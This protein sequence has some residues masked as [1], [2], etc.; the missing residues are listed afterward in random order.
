MKPK[1]NIKSS[2][3]STTETTNP[4]IV[5]A[6][7]LNMQTI[8]YAHL[9]ITI[10]IIYIIV[11]LIVRIGWDH[12]GIELFKNYYQTDKYRNLIMDFLL[13]YVYLK[14]AELLPIN[15]PIVY[16][17]LLIIIF[18]NVGFSFYLNKTSYQTGMIGFLKEWSSTVGWF[19]ILW[20]IFYISSLGKVSDQINKIKLIKKDSIQLSIILLIT[21]ILLHL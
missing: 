21:F 10:I 5:N 14:A 6:Q 1:I 13:S 16:K 11:P 12:K 3:N 2:N 8:G 20:D 19:A 17:R 4:I 9:L 18:F 7:T 15:I